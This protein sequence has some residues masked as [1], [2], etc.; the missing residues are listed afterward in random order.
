MFPNARFLVLALA[1]G[2][3]APPPFA[4]DDKPPRPVMGCAAAVDNYFED[5]VWAKVGV[6]KCLTC[7][8]KGGDAEDSKFVLID[9]RKS[10]G[11]ARDEAMRHNRAAFARMAAVKEKDRSRHAPQGGRRARPRRCGR[12]R[13]RLGGVSHPRRLRPPGERPRDR[14]VRPPSRW[15]PRRRRSSRAS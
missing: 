9:P 6:Q 2:I 14:E 12:A 10:E 15:T 7:H 13:A 8:R 11:A 4:G 1:A 5:E 3:V